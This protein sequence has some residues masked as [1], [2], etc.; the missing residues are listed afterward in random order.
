VVYTSSITQWLKDFVA[1]A[2]TALDAHGGKL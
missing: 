1:D 2:V